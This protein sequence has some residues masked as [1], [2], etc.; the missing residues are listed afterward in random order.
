VLL[1]L[2]LFLAPVLI[3]I[4]TLGARRWGPRVGGWLTGLPTVAG[5]TLVFYAFEQGT[6]FAARASHATLVGL[7]AIPWFCVAYA[8]V[9]RRAGWAVSLI[10][11]WTTFV[12]GIAFL[13]LREINLF[14]TWA[15]LAVNCA[16]GYMALPAHTPVSAEQ[17]HSKWDLPSRMLAAAVLVTVLTAVADI[18][19][20]Q[21]SG[22]LA[23]FPVATAI[24][25][26]FTHKQRG[27]DAVV[28]FFRGFLPAL[29]S[30]GLFCVVLAVALEPLGIA[31]ALTLALV[32]QLSTQVVT[33]WKMTPGPS[34]APQP[35]GAVS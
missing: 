29:V 3:A 11:G 12:F 24:V 25:A 18:L 33:L 22:L 9:G 34:S 7:V 16:A 5:P 13:S 28:I 26:A 32:V 30:F 27:V 8:Y 19:G 20:P 31:R 1:L 6:A 23:P 14:V 15:L 2:K 35:G 10:A 4:V 17:V 21:L